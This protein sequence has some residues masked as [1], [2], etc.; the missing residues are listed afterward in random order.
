MFAR[1]DPHC[2]DFC[3]ASTQHRP[4]REL[5]IL[6]AQVSRKPAKC[7]LRRTL[8]GRGSRCRAGT[9]TLSSRRTVW[10]VRLARSRC[11]LPAAAPT[12]WGDRGGQKQAHSTAPLVSDR[13][14]TAAFRLL[15][16]GL[17]SQQR[18]TMRKWAQ[19]RRNRAVLN[20]PIPV[21]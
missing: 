2:R 5:N 3:L 19:A 1:E 12:S 20:Y 15:T 8:P 21:S 4:E 10:R 18:I 17:I 7:R 16:P 11:R 14:S 6:C 13:A 9:H